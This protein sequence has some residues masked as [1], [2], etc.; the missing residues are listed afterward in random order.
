MSHPRPWTS[1][2][3]STG[4]PATEDQPQPE[5]RVRCGGIGLC[6]LCST[7]AQNATILFIR[8]QESR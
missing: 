3:H 4:V 5:R 2:G 1:H 6:G 8:E 7:E